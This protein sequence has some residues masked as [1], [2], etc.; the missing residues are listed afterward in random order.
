[1]KQ[2]PGGMASPYRNQNV[3]NQRGDEDNNEEEE[4]EMVIEDEI[5]DFVI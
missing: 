4:D 3:P 5:D 1:M 2:N